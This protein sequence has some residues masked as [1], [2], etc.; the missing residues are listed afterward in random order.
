MSYNILLIEDN[1][2]MAE[3]IMSI[4]ELAHYNVTHAPNGK[5]GVEIAQ[6]NPPDLI[7][8]DIMM[9]ELDGY[10]VVHILNKDPE[11]ASI[12][13]IFLTAKT[14]KSD[15]RTGM[16]LGAD[17]YITKPFDGVDLLKVVEIRLKKNELLKSSYSNHPKDVSS[18]FSKAREIKEFQK[19]SDNRPTRSFKKKDLIFMEGQTPN[20]LYHIEEGRVKTYK[21]NYDGKE[22]ITGIHSAGDF[23]G[24]VPLL[25][26]RPYNENAEA[27]EDVRISIIP[28]SDF[29]TLIYSSKDVARTFIKML[30]NNLEEMENRLLDIAYQSVR[31]RVASALLKIN[32]RFAGE[33]EDVIITIARKD[34]SNIVGTAT[35]SLNR[36]LADF[37]DEG[38]IE[39]SGEGLKVVN[40]AKLEKLLR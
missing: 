8:C 22:L 30:S 2:E 11:T 6:R 9:P 36:T 39:I 27:L 24:Y 17:D 28:K 38:L 33:D 26:E 3:N 12:P 4:L 32:S 31:Q 23:L 16:N 7:L 35:E 37:R 15:F 21:I 13:F 14:D 18:F 34:I 40:K 10:G 29:L 1:A 20:D 25:E 19:L 5:K